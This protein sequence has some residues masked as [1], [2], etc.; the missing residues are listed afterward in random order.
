M[1]LVSQEKTFAVEAPMEDIKPIFMQN[2]TFQNAEKSLQKELLTFL[3]YH[4][5]E[6]RY[7]TGH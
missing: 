2:T 5:S 7:I 6:V 1:C 4:T 3:D